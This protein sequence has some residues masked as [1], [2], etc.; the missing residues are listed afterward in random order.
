MTTVEAALRSM[1]ADGPVSGRSDHGSGAIIRLLDVLAALAGLLFFL[2]TLLLIALAVRA[3][4]GGPALFRQQRIGR[5]GRPFACLK[6]RSMTPDAE[7]RLPQ[8]A[9]EEWAERRKFRRDPR[10][11]PLGR[12]LRLSSLDELPQLINVLIG[13]MSLVGPRPIVP[14]EAPLYGRRFAAYCAV[15]PGLTGLWQVSG[16]ND[17]SYP[18]RVAMDVWLVRNLTVRIYLALLIRTVPAVLRREG[19]Y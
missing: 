8:L 4:D 14:D 19:V 3:Q 11:T 13:D 5:D 1:D 2:P 15:R 9:D 10:V 12:F 6:F 16:R 7:A 17:V 18:R